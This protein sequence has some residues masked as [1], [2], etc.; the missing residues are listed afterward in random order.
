MNNDYSNFEGKPFSSTNWLDKHHSIKSRIRAELIHQ[1]PITSSSKILDIGCG[2]GQWSL[3]LAE[4]IGHKGI[5]VGVDQDNESIKLA[6]KKLLNHYLQDNIIFKCENIQNFTTDMKFDLIVLFNSL[7]YISKPL[8]F[9]NSLSKHLNKNGAILIKDTDLGSDFF[10]PI[11]I[12]LYHKLMLEI[13]KLNTK[14]INNYDPF[15]ARKIPNLLYKSHFSRFE[16]FLQSF[17]FSYP[18]D[19]LE[20]EYI[21]NNADMIHKLASNNDNSIETEEWK[22]QFDNNSEAC[23]FDKHDFLY[24]MTDFLFYARMPSN[25]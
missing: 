25:S 12:E 6:K 7:S 23:I 3:L 19:L 2:T 17:S 15:F 4:K 22:K 1:L 5:V 13:N 21:A 24:T 16:T 14:K 11:N 10:W 9:I 20:R 18:V 8:E